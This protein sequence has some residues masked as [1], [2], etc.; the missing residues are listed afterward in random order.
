[1]YFWFR[2]RVNLI[3]LWVGLGLGL[4]WDL[5]LTT[6][7]S[8]PLH[9]Q[10]FTLLPWDFLTILLSNN[11]Q[12][13]ATENGCVQRLGPNHLSANERKAF[14]RICSIQNTSRSWCLVQEL[15]VLR[16]KY[17]S[18]HRIQIWRTTRMAWDEFHQIEASQASF[19][20][21]QSYLLGLWGH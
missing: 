20:K 6:D 18:I 10:A 16:L 14:G 11:D 9:L 2:I 19:A 17:G 21:L 12:V 5:Y 13:A 8:T 15:S 7:P 1:M 3:G 4:A